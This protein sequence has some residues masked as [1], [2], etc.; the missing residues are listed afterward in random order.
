MAVG[1][2]RKCETA[3]YAMFVSFVFIPQMLILM[4]VYTFQESGMGHEIIYGFEEMYEPYRR[5]W[6]LVYACGDLE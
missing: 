4:L 2:I 1:L 6:W 3:S 5:R